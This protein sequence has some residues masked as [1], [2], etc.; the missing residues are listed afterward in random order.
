MDSVHYVRLVRLVRRLLQ[1]H[2][3][4]APRGEEPHHGDCRQDTHDNSND[5]PEQQIRHSVNWPPSAGQR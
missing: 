4:G 5:L 2:L 1:E 3:R